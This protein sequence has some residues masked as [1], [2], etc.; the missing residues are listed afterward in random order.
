MPYCETFGQLEAILSPEYA[1]KMP[2]WEILGKV[3]VIILLILSECASQMPDWEAFGNLK[4]IALPE[5]A[6]KMQGW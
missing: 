5:H 4:A 1:L 2:G 3:K 6:L